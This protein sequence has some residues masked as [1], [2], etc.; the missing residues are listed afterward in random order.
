MSNKLTAI[1]IL[2]YNNYRDTINCIESI[3]KHNK[4]SIKY[5][6]VDNGSLHDNVVRELDI[7]LSQKFSSNYSLIY[8][9]D[10]APSELPYCTLLSSSTNTGYACGNKKGLSLAYTDKTIDNVL[11]LNNDVLFIEDFIETLSNRLW[12]DENSIIST[13]VVLK[14]DGVSVDPNCARK[15]KGIFYITFWFLLNP[16]DILGLLK[17]VNNKLYY[18]GTNKQEY[19]QELS[20]DMPSGSCFMA[21]KNDFKEIEDFDSYTF[22]FYEEDILAKKIKKQGKKCI[23]IPNTYCIHLGSGSTKSVTSDYIYKTAIRSA[24]YYIKE[25]CSAN[26]L[27]LVLFDISANIGR[28]LNGVMTLFFK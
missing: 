27:Q 5:I 28:L 8:D 1:I 6:I 18:F 10:K 20:I 17:R 25:Y 14:K 13:P 21:K 26:L 12:C 15:F 22:L 19:T 4:S 24:R 3:E 9:N 7:Y 16:I 11:I 2:N 23:L